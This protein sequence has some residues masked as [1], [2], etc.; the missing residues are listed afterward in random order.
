MKYIF[1]ISIL[2]S[3]CC[4][5]GFKGSDKK[6]PVAKVGDRY[7]Y[8]SEFN[9]LIKPG[10]Q[11]N[12]SIAMIGSLIEKWI[13]KQLILQR[14][15]LNLTEDEKNVDKELDD[16]RTS[17]LIFKYEQKFIQEK[18]DTIVSNSEIND[19]YNKNT[20]NFILNYDIVKALFIKIPKPFSNIDKIK[21]WMRNESDENIK[22]LEGYCV[23][24]SLKY[25]YFNDEWV[26]FDNL[27]MLM[28]ISASSAEQ[29]KNNVIVQ[30]SDSLAT[31]LL[32]VKDF[33]PRG[34]VSP[35]SFMEKDIKSI[36]L[37]KRKQK[38]INDLEN[39]IYFDAI[40]KSNFTIY[41]EKQ[42]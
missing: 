40:D 7:L 39:E 22:E 4:C 6:K 10:Y 25:D 24:N 36:I 8:S 21:E 23:T 26:N 2:F 9:G 37:L 16:Y 35:L 1:L 33:K 3:L 20:S 28:P 11:K 29:A 17:L 31:Y 30:S 38:M 14:A 15:E 41:K 42:K 12:D 13:R 27:K 18:L 5:S 32:H 19:Y 34:S